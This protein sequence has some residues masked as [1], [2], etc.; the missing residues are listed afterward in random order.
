MSDVALPEAAAIAPVDTDALSLPLPPVAAATKFCNKCGAPWQP[1]WQQCGGCTA[2]QQRVMVVPERETVSQAVWMYF[3]LLAVSIVALI[4]AFSGADVMT[5]T[6]VMMAADSA[7][8]LGYCV[9]SRRTI[10]NALSKAVSPGWFPVA[11]GLAVLTYLLASGLLA[12]VRALLKIPVMD[13]SAPF[14]SNGLLTAILII[15]VQPAIIEELGFRGVI[16]PALQPALAPNEAVL[17]SALM[18]MMLHLTLFSFPH[19]FVMGVVLGYLRVRTGSLLPGMLLH[20]THNL[21][22]VLGEQYWGH[23]LNFSVSI[24]HWFG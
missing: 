21:L 2:W 8:V 7:I 10:M 18:F 15:C 23:L 11:A 9:R 4:A 5:L 1:D 16:L 3:A 13:E 24:H 6:L 12:I 14:M 22:C 17:V 19:L 20:F